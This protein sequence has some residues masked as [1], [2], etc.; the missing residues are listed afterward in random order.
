MAATLDRDVLDIVLRK[1]PIDLRV[2]L[3][4]PPN[5]VVMSDDVRET[6]TR[7]ARVAAHPNRLRYTW[8]RVKGVD[9]LVRVISIV[10]MSSSVRYL[11]DSR[12]TYV[13]DPPTPWYEYIFAC[14]TKRA[15]AVTTRGFTPFVEVLAYIDAP[16]FVI[17]ELEECE[18]LGDVC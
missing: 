12:T 9:N 13:R 8:A 2:A 5:Q 14:R 16:P 3:R 11:D 17:A 1:L 6:L 10:R 7:M 15:C 18:A 4:V